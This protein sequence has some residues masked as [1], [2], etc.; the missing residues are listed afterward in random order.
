MRKK[1]LTL[2]LCALLLLTGLPL[3]A[4]AVWFSDVSASAWYYQ[5]VMSLADQ[6]IV[7]GGAPDPGSLCHH[8][9]QIHSF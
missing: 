3:R 9:C 1:A 5:A 8:A 7:A 2:A 6:G 4:H